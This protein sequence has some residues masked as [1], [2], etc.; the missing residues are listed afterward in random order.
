MWFISVVQVASA[1]VWAAYAIPLPQPISENPLTTAMIMDTSSSIL[2]AN[3]K[4]E[5]LPEYDPEDHTRGDIEPQDLEMYF[6]GLSRGARDLKAESSPRRQI[7]NEPQ[8]QLLTFDKNLRRR[9][10]VLLGLMGERNRKMGKDYATREAVVDGNG[11]RV[12]R[13]IV[14]GCKPAGSLGSLAPTPPPQRKLYPGQARYNTESPVVITRSC[15]YNVIGGRIC[16][17]L[18]IQLYTRP[19]AK[20]V[21]GDKARP[22]GY[23]RALPK[24]FPKTRPL[25]ARKRISRSAWEGYSCVNFRDVD[26]GKIADAGSHLNKEI[27]ISLLAKK[28]IN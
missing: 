13:K 3:L 28:N 10:Y 11:Q 4:G 9:Q 22:P 15:L 1:F 20:L 26:L 8:E 12:R 25:T 23:C 7:L 19:E 16:S 2:S 6:S 17:P 24:V 27:T 21:V 14:Q 5:E 18:H